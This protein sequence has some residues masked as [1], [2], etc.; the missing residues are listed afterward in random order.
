MATLYGRGKGK[1]GSHKPAASEKSNFSSLSNQEIEEI[2]LKLAKQ[3]NNSA[4][5][6]MILRDT[7]GV[8]N[9][10]ITLGKKVEKI[11][12]ENKLEHEPNELVSMEKQVKKLKKH[13]EK[14]KQD[15]TAKRG[16]QLAE[17]KLRRLKSNYK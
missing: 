7:Y 5:I 16:L 11:L 13:F 10:R 2:I 3:G 14:N 8:G 9:I 6:G 12:D 1:A 4:K 15:M 17:A